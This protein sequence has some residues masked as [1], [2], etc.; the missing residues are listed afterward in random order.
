MRKL[1]GIVLLVGA[2]VLGWR[3]W[4]QNQADARVWASATD[5][6]R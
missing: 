3:L 1:F 6:V 4:Q 2:A 5:R